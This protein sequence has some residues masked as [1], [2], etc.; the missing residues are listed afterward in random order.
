MKRPSYHKILTPSPKVEKYLGGLQ[1]DVMELMWARHPLT[2][3]EVLRELSAN[4]PLAYTTVMTV[5]TRL[6]EKGLL[7][8]IRD[9]KS[10]L[11]EPAQTREQFL[12]TVSRDIVRDLLRDFGPAAVAQFVAQV[13]EASGE[14]LESLER[15]IEQT[16]AAREDSS[17][18]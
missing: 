11:Y 6:A 15:L 14:G 10:F 1:A 13:G 4:R 8:Q 9:R 18:C 3:R 5:M 2:V 12:S 7:R 17:R 16:R